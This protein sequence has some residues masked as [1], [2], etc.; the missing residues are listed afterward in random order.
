M[1]YGM[2]YY[3]IPAS[4]IGVPCLFLQLSIYQCVHAMQGRAG[5]DA[6]I[7]LVPCDRLTQMRTRK[8][9][10]CGETVEQL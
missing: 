7:F 1:E 9:L 10:S 6:L 2:E 3:G 4:P 8:M 5:R